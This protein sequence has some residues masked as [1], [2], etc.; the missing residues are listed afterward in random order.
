LLRLYK[1]DE[2]VAPAALADVRRT[3][4]EWGIMERKQFE[5]EL[6][7]RSLVE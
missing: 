1:Q 7:Q 4:D 3:L 6:R 5:E 2:K